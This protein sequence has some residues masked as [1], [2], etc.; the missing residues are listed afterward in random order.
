MFVSVRDLRDEKSCSSVFIESNELE[1]IQQWFKNLSFVK[2]R[3]KEQN[4]QE[5]YSVKILIH[6]VNEEEDE[7]L[8]I[9]LLIKADD[10]KHI[11]NLFSEL[12]RLVKKRWW[13]W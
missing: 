4:S 1:E 9:Q 12:I 8:K 7:H 11:N 6:A 2:R 5:R 10:R 3:T 13:G